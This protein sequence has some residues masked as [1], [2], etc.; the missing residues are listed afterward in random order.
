M[1]SVA[2]NR[3]NAQ[4]LYIYVDGEIG[5]MPQLFSIFIAGEEGIGQFYVQA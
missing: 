5:Q 4:L 3:L 2:V 1:H